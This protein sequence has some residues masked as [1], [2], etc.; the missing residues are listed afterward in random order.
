MSLMDS[1]KYVLTPIHPEGKKFAVIFAAV[2]LGLFLMSDILGWIGVILTAFCVYFFRNPERI[3][4]DRDDVVISPADGTICQISTCE[5][6]EELDEK[7]QKMTK[8]SIFM[9]VFNVHINR[10]PVSG[11]ILKNV[12]VPGKFL[13]ADL[14][15]ASKDNER[16]LVLIETKKKHKIAYVQIAGLIARRILCFIKKGDKVNMG[17]RFGLIRFGSRLDVYIPTHYEVLVKKGQT[18]VAGETL[19]AELKKKNKQT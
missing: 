7:P 9:S 8:V 10:N 19:L 6:P 14:D 2:T 5:F 13:N 1:A 12:Y 15:K 18:M 17:D 16:N 4:P 3:S 11:K